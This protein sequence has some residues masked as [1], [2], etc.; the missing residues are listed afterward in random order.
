MSVW[1]FPSRIL[2][3]ISIG[4][5]AKDNEFKWVMKDSNF[6]IV[7]VKEKMTIK[8]QMK[9]KY[10]KPYLWQMSPDS[11]APVLQCFE[12]GLCMC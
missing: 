9:S 12:S 11:K 1:I 4:L 6:G 3:G 10:G 5:G 7:E 2:H 8:S